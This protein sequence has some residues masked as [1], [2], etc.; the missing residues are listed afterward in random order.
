MKFSA[1][2]ILGGQA[3]LLIS[4]QEKLLSEFHTVGFFAR[5]LQISFSNHAR[6]LW[7]Y[8][9]V[10]FLT[11]GSVTFHDFHRDDRAG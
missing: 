4:A 5:H 9:L 10:S 3:G 8:A 6:K 11:Q 2:P 1:D 7:V